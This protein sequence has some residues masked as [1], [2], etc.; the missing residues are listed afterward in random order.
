MVSTMSKTQHG[1]TLLARQLFLFGDG[2]GRPVTTLK[3]LAKRTGC[4]E[5]NLARR[6]PDWTREREALLR[7]SSTINLDISAETLRKHADDVAFLRERADTLEAEVRTSDAVAETL[8]AALVGA[9]ADEDLHQTLN[10]FI[11]SA[12]NAQKATTQFL[13]VQKRWVENSGIEA[14]LKAFSASE[15]EKARGLARLSVKSEVT[16]VELPLPSNRPV[17]GVFA[18]VKAIS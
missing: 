12:M 8:R 6:V 4:S 17:Q 14:K 1:K 10:S 13:A 9:G 11:K 3:T 7:E 16:E 15:T 18:R 2:D 5:C